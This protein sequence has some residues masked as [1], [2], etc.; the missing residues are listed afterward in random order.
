[1][2]IN[3]FLD[4]RIGGPHNY[5]NQINKFTKQ[6]NKWKNENNHIPNLQTSEQIIERIKQQLKTQKN[7]Q[8]SFDGRV[9]SIEQKLDRLMKHLGVK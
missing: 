6:Y 9:T 1:M 8:Q 5:S 3:F 7:Q 4:N 2:I